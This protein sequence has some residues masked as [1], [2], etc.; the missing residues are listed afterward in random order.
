MN[1]RNRYICLLIGLCAVFSFTSA[2]G[3]DFSELEKAVSETTLDNGLKVIVMER[4]D[5]PVVS[6]VTFANVGGANDPNNLTGIAHML[7]H[8]AFKGTTTIGTTDIDAELAAMA[9]EDSL[10]ALIRTERLKG[11]LADQARLEA[12]EAEFEVA[13]EAARAFIKT[14]AWDGLLE[15]EGAVGINAGTGKDNTTYIMSLPSNKVELWMYMESERFKNLVLRSMYQEKQVVAEERR[16]QFDNSPIMRTLGMLQAIAFEAHPYG[17]PVVGHMSDI[18]NFTRASVRAYFEENYVPSNMI[19]SIVGDVKAKDVLKMAEKYF[20]R[21]EAKPKPDPIATVEP[22]QSG[23][24]FATLEDPSQP[25]LVS[26]Y[27]IP[28]NTDPDWPAVTTMMNYLGDGRTSPLYENLVKEKKIASV[29]GAQW[30]PGSAYPCLCMIY[31]MP[32]PES[33]NDACHEQILAEIERLKTEPLPVE[34]IDKIKA[35]AKAGF[36]N[37]LRSNLGLA[38]QLASFQN[39]WGDWREAFKEL[40]RI[41]AVTP[42][43]VQRVANKYLVATNRTVVHLNTVE[44]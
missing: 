18:Q 1:S 39:Y 12:L 38:N 30:W 29:V 23:E 7:E 41:N 11:R 6:C 4:H 32:A 15:E 26:G 17:I 19:V 40:D 25:L 2:F 8:M 34:A 28:S 10:V 3:F 9:V 35:Q 24:R 44:N 13:K 33:T 21:L 43:E 5:A 14:N 27:H 16:Q 20:G 42:E 37:G 36:I 31:A 22:E